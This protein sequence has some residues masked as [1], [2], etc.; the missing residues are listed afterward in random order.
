LIACFPNQLASQ[1]YSS[2]TVQRFTGL[3]HPTNVAVDAA[4]N[5]YVTHGGTNRVVK[6][7]VG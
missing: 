2:Q 4:G 3:K 1:A 7:P 6:L 5:V